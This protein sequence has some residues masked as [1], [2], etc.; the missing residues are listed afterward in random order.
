MIWSMMYLLQ[1]QP[2]PSWSLDENFDWQP[3]MPRPEKGIG[4]QWDEDSGEWVN[5]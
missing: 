5:G 4:W 2:Y 3:P 1:P